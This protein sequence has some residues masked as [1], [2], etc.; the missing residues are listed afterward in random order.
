LIVSSI[1]APLSPN[2]PLLLITRGIQAIGTSALYP[3]G[4]GIIRNNI[5]HNQNRVIGTLSVF[6]TTSAAFG[7]TI[8][9]LLIQFGGWPII[10]YVNL[11]ILALGIVIRS[12]YIPKDEKSTEKSSKMDYIDIL[13]FSSLID[14]SMQKMTIALLVVAILI[15][16]GMF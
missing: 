13:L 9:G 1:L 14:A 3:A 11:P 16:P 2:M 7:P 6:A 15:I 8:S 5:H 10:F 4:I 12:I